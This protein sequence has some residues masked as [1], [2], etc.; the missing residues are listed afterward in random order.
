MSKVRL[1]AFRKA[2]SSDT[3]DTTYELDLSKA[4]NISV[5][6][7]FSD[8]KEPDK[9]KG[10][11]SQTFKLPFTTKNN[12][13]FENWF[14]VNIETQVFNT[15]V[16]FDAAL[17]VGTVPQIEGSIQLR[18][19]YKKGQYYE[20]SIFSNTA[21]LFSVIGEQ[22]LK[23]VFRNADGSYSTDLNHVF[24]AANVGY[25]WDGD[26]SSFVNEP[27]GVSLRDA[28]SEVQKVMYPLS[29]RERLFK[30]PEDSN[31]E[32]LEKRFLRNDGTSGTASGSNA[33]S[34]CV[35]I[36]QFRPAIQIKEMFKR[37]LGKS[38]F[39]YTSNFIDG[40]YFGKLFM[41]TG[42]HLGAETT[43]I[44][45]TVEVPS[46]FCHVGTSASTGWGELSGEWATTPTNCQFGTYWSAFGGS[47]GFDVENDT[48]DIYDAT[49]RYFTKKHPTMNTLSLRHCV[50]DENIIQ[51]GTDPDDNNQLVT[52][53]Y[54]LVE[55][56]SDGN[57][58]AGSELVVDTKDINVGQYT[59]GYPG[60]LV[61]KSLD[62]ESIP[63]GT[64]FRIWI[65]RTNWRPGESPFTDDFEFTLGETG[66]ISNIYSQTAFT[67]IACNCRAKITWDGYDR[68]TYGNTV[69]IPACIDP[70]ITQK[71]FL[72]DII[73]RFN[74]VIV[75]DPNNAANLIIEP[76]RDYVGQG[77][78]KYW[79]DKLDTSKEVII[80]DTVDLQKKTIDFSDQEDDDYLN[81]EFKESFPNINVYGHYKKEEQE[82]QFAKGVLKN[83]SIF[84]PYINSKVWTNYD[85]DETL[86]PN[87]V[88]QYEYSYSVDDDNVVEISQEPTKP[89]LFY[90]CG[91][92]T[93]VVDESGTSLTYY[94]HSIEPIT[95]TISYH[96]FQ[97]YPLCSPYDISS[98]SSFSSYTLTSANS[99]LYWSGAP[100][101][102]YDATVFNYEPGG[103]VSLTQNSLFFKYWKVYLDEL[104]S[105][106]ARI[107]ECYLN[108]NEVDIL[109]FKFNDEIFIKDTY[110]RILKIQNYQVG[111][112][113]STKVTL[114]KVIDSLIPYAGCTRVVGQVSG[115][116]NTYNGY[117]LWVD[118][119]D[120]SA[121]PSYPNGL[122]AEPQCCISM[123]GQVVWNNT[124]Q[125]SNNRYLC[126]ADASSAPLWK[127]DIT[128]NK[129]I[130]S[131]P[132][133]KNVL[134]KKLGR[135]NTPL[136]TGSNISK[137]TKS[138][139]PSYGD[140]IV[141]K[142]NTTP[143]DVPS[144]QGENHRIMLV[145]YTEGTT[146]GYAYVQGDEL[147]D[148]IKIPPNSNTRI[149]VKA[150]VTVIGGEDASYT[151]GHTDII[152]HYTAFISMNGT[153]TQIGTAGGVQEYQ[154][155]Q[156]SSRVS[157]YI[158]VSESE[159]R[160]GLKDS[161]AQ[162]KRI[163]TINLD[164][165]VQEINNLNYP[166]KAN[167]ALYQDQSP[168]NLQDY[169]NLLWN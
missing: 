118:A 114:L 13:F 91:E 81:K 59:L 147:L 73:Q 157:L 123:G 166:Y 57:V 34:I 99:S 117:Y 6:Y 42:G 71:A 84:A 18:A 164:M 26:S 5:N 105:T 43:P 22:R 92:R 12:A 48:G 11:Y 56:D 122:Y 30:Y 160:I 138:L 108:L 83:E 69:D 139:L 10:T 103:N 96:S 107:M 46:G 51:C 153:I 77:S 142:Y 55:I 67:S 27:A 35:D 151:L 137:Y 95:N 136:R 54:R 70:E 124:A 116:G 120:A 76:Y 20:V 9:R 145:G 130:F 129:N 36:T 50:E 102:A 135:A 3:N 52:L 1:L 126:L 98:G 134:S 94:M 8:I 74:L 25:S 144:L 133:I 4:P 161:L 39:S 24:N 88:V 33:W 15:G 49:G 106:D 104:Y 90:Y 19:V 32:N 21:D 38:G 165:D 82:N 149:N 156:T 29:V 141:I 45:E 63:V 97:Q 110:W 61:S 78:I 143:I 40:N 89:K 155:N 60:L 121:T 146:T 41:T 64:R 127:Q 111:E 168:I 167:Y 115:I 37:I 31:N 132:G 66:T 75:A 2:T 150:T 158:D 23:D 62:I 85:F 140:D 101:V 68:N 28:D 125:A 80:K 128:N 65:R 17:Y 152:A 72:K 119:T 87:M 154:L 163:W 112:L 7:Q 14:D 131:D 148:R 58:V 93:T 16:K 113:A 86:L 79:T 162:T 169:E 159:L 109:N 47:Q 53:E 44:I 100:P